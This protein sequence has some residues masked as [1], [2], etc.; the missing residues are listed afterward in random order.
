MSEQERDVRHRI[1]TSRTH[2]YMHPCMHMDIDP[3]QDRDR[4]KDIDRHRYV[5]PLNES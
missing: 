1:D 2:P 5:T 3:D 4:D